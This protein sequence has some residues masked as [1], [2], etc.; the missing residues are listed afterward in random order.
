MK[1]DLGVGNK[2]QEGFTGVDIVKE[3]TQADIE[4]NL[5]I[6]PWPF[7][8]N[9]IDEIFCSHFIEHIPHGD[10]FNDPFFN[11]MNEA[12]RVLKEEGTATFITPYYTSMRAWQDP[13]HN[14]VIAEA[15]YAYLDPDWRRENKLE[16][17]PIK[18]NFK[19]TSCEYIYHE[20]SQNIDFQDQQFGLKHFWNV[21]ADMKVVLKK[22]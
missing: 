10:G 9:S 15:T 11:F 4:H 2:K 20:D 1:L 7:K 3:G 6:F 17:Y 19:V 5:L 13:T 21:G 8:D 18:A 14:R 22:I 16:H 12:W